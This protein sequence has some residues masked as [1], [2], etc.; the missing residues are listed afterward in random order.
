MEILKGNIESLTGIQLKSKLYEWKKNT[1]I[2]GVLEAN[3]ALPTSS[4]KGHHHC[5]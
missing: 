3:K 2:L 5:M 4:E 1:H